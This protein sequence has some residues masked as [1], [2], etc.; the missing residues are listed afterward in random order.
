MKLSAQIIH[1]LPGIE[2][3]G[4]AWRTLSASLP[5][6]TGLFTS[7]DYV[8]AC[9]TSFQSRDWRVVAISDAENG[10]LQAV[11]PLQL[12]NLQHDGHTFLAC[13]PLT[14]GI[15]PYVEL[16]SRSQTRR[17]VLSV[18]L[19]DV[20]HRHLHVDLMCFWPLHEASPLY[21]CLLEDM[22]PATLKTLRFPDN[23]AQIDS[24]GLD[25]DGWVASQPRITFANA[26][27]CE[28][29][30]RKQGRKV[31]FQYADRAPVAEL[32]PQLCSWNEAK[33]K[34][35]YIYD[36][37][38]GWLESLTALVEQLTARGFAE[39]STLRVD[40]RVVSIGLSF[41][42]RSRRTFFMYDYDPAF[43]SFSVSK[44]LLSHL[45]EQT[46]AEGG[47]FCFGAGSQAYKRDWTQAVGELKAA[48]VFLNPA[49][50]PVLDGEL[51][52]ANIHRWF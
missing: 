10:Q 38:P 42:F 52:P 45:I 26:R 2:A 30:L 3:L 14:L 1:D 41:R 8:R 28:R 21:L 33:F 9:L 18:L 20:L 44:I 17:Q 7:W 24:R 22:A 19:G 15:A 29:R 23:L 48:F 50:R 43:A 34:E 31:E 5:D 4:P 32:L 16:P 13:K 11:F 6:N 39:L 47:I 25:I 49:V 27:Y 35:A 37:R 51:I 12:F 46:F 36:T 40:C